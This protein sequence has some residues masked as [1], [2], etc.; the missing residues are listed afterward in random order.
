MMKARRLMGLVQMGKMMSIRA[1]H[2]NRTQV[3]RRLR[4]I[5]NAGKII[6]DPLVAVADS[7]NRVSNHVMAMS[8]TEFDT[9]RLFSFQ[10]LV[11]AELTH[12]GTS[13]LCTVDPEADKF[14]YIPAH[15]N[16][17]SSSKRDI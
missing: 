7:L 3:C 10:A 1:A 9:V 12:A 4:V 17:T 5:F 6:H 14:V 2:W 13:G 8:L 16:L 15:K 11:V